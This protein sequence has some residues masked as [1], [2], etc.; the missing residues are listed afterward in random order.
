LLQKVWQS[1]RGEFV[2]QETIEVDS[3]FGEEYKGTYVFREISWSKRNRIIQKHTKYHPVSG[4]VV[5]SDYVAIQAETIFASLK[6]Q[7]KNHP[8][9]L[10]WLLCEDEGVPF[11]VGE[12]FS[13]VVNRLCSV[14]VDESRFLS[15]QSGEESPTKQS[16]GSGC[17]KSSGSPHG[18]LTGSRRKQSRSLC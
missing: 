15:G 13:Q 6:K 8:I 11:E 16:Q 12:L 2:R 7:P 9:S 3:H 5:S 4:T 17:A 1:A 18:S 14:T 10:E